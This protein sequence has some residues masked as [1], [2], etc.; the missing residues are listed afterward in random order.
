MKK[1][2]KT[3][4]PLHGLAKSPTGIKG[5]D[6]IT[7]GG[8]PKGRPTLIC[9]PAGCGKTLLAME[10]LV[11]GAADYDEPGV[12]LAFEETDHELAQNVSSLGFNLPSLVAR[13]KLVV[14]CV[15]IERSEIEESGDYDLEGLFIRLGHTIDSIGAMRVTVDTI[16]VLFATLP[17][18]AIVRSEIRRLFRWLK[19]KGVT[20]VVTAEKGDGSFTRHGLEEYVADC[21]ITLD[22][23]V[24][25]QIATRRLQ[26]VKYR[27]TSHG[28]NQ[29]S[30]LNE[31]RGFSVL[32]A[33]SMGLDYQV[34]SERVSSGVPRLDAMLGGEGFHC[35]SNI[36]VS[37][38][39]GTGK[40]SLAGAFALAACERGERCLY[41]AFEEAASQIARNLRSIARDLDTWVENGKLRFH[42]ECPSGQ[43]L[44]SHLVG[45]C[46]LIDRFK[47]RIVILD[48]VTNFNSV[49]CI[50]DVKSML[51]RLLDFLKSKQITL[52]C[53][54]LTGGGDNEQQSEVGISSLMDTWL[55]V[56]NLEANGERNRGLYILKSRGTAHSNQ[57]RE[58]VLSERGIELID[59][60]VG[61]LTGSAR[62]AQDA[63]ERA[64][65]LA[66]QQE[67]E[68]KQREIKRRQTVAEAEIAALRAKVDMG[69][70]ELKRLSNES[71][72]RTPALAAAQAQLSRGRMADA[73]TSGKGNT[74]GAGRG[75]KTERRLLKFAA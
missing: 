31:E 17:N 25:D 7:N 3:T 62:I 39:A 70:E 22:H 1:A 32:P 60:Y 16:E 73:P 64:A 59:V 27:G 69:E 68:A 48:P 41:F 24:T 61:E 12:F 71:V 54:S 63:R 15:Q 26:I 46:H 53:T 33:T 52:P 51:S 43:R 72:A 6:E 42:A 11:R 2:I 49:G 38:T 19:D 8:L 55:L 29:Y 37:R 47:P 35:D 45:I 10:F 65:A 34:P 28:T 58:F 5:L 74:S 44:E 14:D 18:A 40:T 36:L 13:K 30:F 20:S 57:V 56:R 75:Q 9:G 67:I 4:A 21:V 66:A 50:E 23:R